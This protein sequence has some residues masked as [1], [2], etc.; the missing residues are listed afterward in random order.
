MSNQAFYIPS[1]GV[2]KIE[3][4]LDENNW[5]TTEANRFNEDIEMSF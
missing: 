4:D 1:G 3:Y 5:F 2:G